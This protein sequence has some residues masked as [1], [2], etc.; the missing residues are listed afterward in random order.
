MHIIPDEIRD[1]ALDHIK[2]VERTLR[3]I[4]QLS[5]GPASCDHRLI[6]NYILYALARIQAAEGTVNAEHSGESRGGLAS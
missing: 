2:E 3:L 5:R 1:R 6:H 4:E